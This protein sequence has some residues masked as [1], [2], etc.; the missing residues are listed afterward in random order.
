MFVVY[1]PFR[2]FIFLS[3]L[4]G[5][6][7]SILIIR[8]LN[9]YFNGDGNG[10]IQSLIFASIFLITSVQLAI[11]A[12]I[13]DLLSINRKLLEDIQTRIKKIELK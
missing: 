13:G 7:G 10:H 12:I 6:V 11:I 3:L 4:F 2:F 8:F 1:R 5:I 9:F